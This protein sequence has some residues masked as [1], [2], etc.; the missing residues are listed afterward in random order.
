MPVILILTARY[1]RIKS[2]CLL[3]Y[4]SVLWGKMVLP[5]QEMEWV[6]RFR[7]LLNG[8]DKNDLFHWQLCS[9]EGD[10]YCNVGFTGRTC[11]VEVTEKGIQWLQ[12]AWYSCQ[13]VMCKVLWIS[14]Q[15][16]SVISIMVAVN[17]C[18]W[19]RK[20]LLSVVAEMDSE[21]ASMARAV[22][23]RPETLMNLPFCKYI[24]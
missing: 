18:A 9:S 10:C 14:S 4:W 13:T 11:Q 15:L 24:L 17:S 23:V 12:D 5:V 6:Y 3:R 19:W 16:I 7:C 20:D 2:V 22:S 8:I 21:W 1:V